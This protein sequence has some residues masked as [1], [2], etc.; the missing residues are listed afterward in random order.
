MPQSALVSGRRRQPLRRLHV[1]DQQHVGAV[2]V[3]LEPLVDVLAQH[4]RRERPERLAELD[5]QVHHRLHLRR[6][7]VADDRAAAER[8]RAE[9]HPA[10]KQADDL[11]LRH[12]RGDAIGQLGRLVRGAPCSRSRRRSAAISSSSKLRPEKRPAHAVGV[13]RHAVLAANGRRAAPTC[14]ALPR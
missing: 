2:A 3:E 9:L 11:F 8:A 6:P 5:L 4:R 7:R 14:R 13:A 10:L 1:G 12:Q